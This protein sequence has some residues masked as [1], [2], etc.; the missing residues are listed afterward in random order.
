MK[1]LISQDSIDLWQR[2]Q[3]RRYPTYLFLI[4]SLNLIVAPAVYGATGAI[5]DKTQAYALGL[6]ALVTIALGVYLFV[7]MFQ[8]ERF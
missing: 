3:S 8:P 1:P 2:W 6:L 7:V 4:L 5:L